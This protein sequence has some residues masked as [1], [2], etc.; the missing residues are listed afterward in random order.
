MFNT[1]INIIRFHYPNLAAIYVYGSYAKGTQT[2]ESDIDICV[3]CHGEVLRFDEVLNREITETIGKDVHVV[4]C[5]Q[6]NEWCLKEI[7]NKEKYVH[8]T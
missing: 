7:Y 3:L 8:V 4:F 6:I 5:T 1:I 2:D